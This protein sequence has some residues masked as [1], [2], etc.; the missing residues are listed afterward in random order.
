MR[1]PLYPV[2]PGS[3]WAWA[4]PLFHGRLGRKRFFLWTLRLLRRIRRFFFIIDS[5]R[6]AEMGATAFYEALVLACKMQ[7]CSTNRYLVALTDGADSDIGATLTSAQEALK[8]GGA[9]VFTVIL[10]LLKQS[11][12]SHRKK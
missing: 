11:A 7:P 4:K 2:V 9:A 12:C 3:P 1:Y 10:C 5:T 8:A 6:H